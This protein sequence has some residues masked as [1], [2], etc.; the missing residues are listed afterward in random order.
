MPQSRNRHSLCLT[1]NRSKFKIRAL[2]LGL[3]FPNRCDCC[4]AR[5]PYDALICSDCAAEID[6]CR[7]SNDAWRAASSDAA[8]PWD[9][10]ATVCAYQG[11]ARAGVLAM[12][13]GKTNF[14]RFIGAELADSVRRLLPD[15]LPDC[16]TWVPMAKR[17]RR[18]QGYAHSER[19]AKETAK[20]LGIPARGDLLIE[21]GGK[22]RQHD[23]PKAARAVYANRFRS[24]GVRLDGKC[25]L[26]CDDVLTTGSTLM[27]CASELRTAG[28][29][30]IY[31]ATAA[32]RIRKQHN[33]DTT[34]QTGKEST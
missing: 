8:L 10:E 4:L 23:L 5:I 26:L 24:T 34:D 17:R 33:P 28:A 25:V 30:R 31:I 27:R 2:L 11:A 13:D 15:A 32:C 14:V 7:L 9:G 29:S 1:M 3:L 12:K 21:E 18:E 20:A 6:A 22:V 19:L 16:V